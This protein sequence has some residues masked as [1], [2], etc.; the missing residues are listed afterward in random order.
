ME[1]NGREKTSYRVFPSKLE[2][3]KIGQSY[4]LQ[5]QKKTKRVIILSVLRC[6]QIEMIQQFE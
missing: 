4:F 5:C 2:L 3:Q 1:T 6:G